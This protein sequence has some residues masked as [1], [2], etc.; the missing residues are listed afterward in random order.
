MLQISQATNQRQVSLGIRE[1]VVQSSNDRVIVMR[2]QSAM[3][4]NI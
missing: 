1:E 2:M 4:K 3:K